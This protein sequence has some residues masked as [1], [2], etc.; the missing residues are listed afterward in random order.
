MHHLAT[1]DDRHL[2]A[3]GRPFDMVF[4][5]RCLRPGLPEPFPP[6]LRGRGPWR[7]QRMGTHARRCSGSRI[8]A[9]PVPR[10]MFRG[11]R[12]T[13]TDRSGALLAADRAIE[14][15]YDHEDRPQLRAFFYLPF[16]HSENL[17][18][19]ER[20]WPPTKNSEFL[21]PAQVRPSSPR[22]HRPVRSLPPPQ[23]APRPE[24]HAGGNCLSGRERLPRLTL[25][26]PRLLA[27]WRRP[28]CARPRPV[29]PRSS[30]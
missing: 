17:S 29:P 27:P 19:Q 11:D 30:A 2:L 5:G 24:Y 26:F 15:G 23:R 12:A 20:S 10:N 3:R 28:L 14:R 16:M 6:H 13:Y 7:P 21:N 1:P 8:A 22:H 25:T 18:D 9:R 4:Q